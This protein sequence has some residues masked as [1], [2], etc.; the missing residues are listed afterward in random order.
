MRETS[1]KSRLED[2]LQDTRSVLPKAVKVAKKKDWEIVTG[3]K[4]QGRRDN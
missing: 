1:E 4:K 3:Q 2:S